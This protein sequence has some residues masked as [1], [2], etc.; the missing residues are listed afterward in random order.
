MAYTQTLGASLNEI[1]RRLATLLLMLIS[2]M[3][4]FGQTETEENIIDVQ[5]RECLDSTENETTDRL[6]KCSIRA[7]DAWDKELNKYYKL[8]MKALTADEKEKLINSQKK[9]VIYRDSEI[10]FTRT[11]YDN[12]QGTT[13]RVVS[14]DRQ[15][16]ITR[17][18]ALEL[19]EYFANI[20]EGK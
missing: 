20:P 17:Q 1:M 7:G 15:T 9:W 11:I 19:K 2:V 4:S 18:R 5:L 16:E 12:L 6:I 10:E 8:L 13:W 14:A 3:T